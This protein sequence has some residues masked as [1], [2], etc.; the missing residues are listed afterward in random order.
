M[1]L[2]FEDS[3]FD[4]IARAE[5]PLLQAKA[6]LLRHRPLGTEVLALE[7]ADAESVFSIA[8]PTPPADSTGAG[9]ILEHMVFRGSRGFPLD[10]PFSAL[11]AGS[12]ASYLNASTR[13]DLTT[14]HG[15]SLHA[16]DLANLTEVCLDAVLNPLLEEAAFRQEAWRREPGPPPALAG[17][18]LNEMKGHWSAPGA[19]LL[20]ALR[21]GLFPDSPYRHAY[22]GDPAAIPDLTPEALRAF[23][24]RFYHPSGAKILLW[25]SA[26]LGPRLAQI[27]RHLEDFAPRPPQPEALGQ[28]PFDAP[29]RVEIGF[30]GEARMSGA[31]WALAAAEAPRLLRLLETALIGLPL[32]PLKSLGGASLIGGSG[33]SLETAQ[34]FLALG[35][36][37]GAPEAVEAALGAR[38]AALAAGD[39]PPG[40]VGAALNQMAFRLR[41]TDG[42]P[43]KPRGLQVWE[44]ILGPWRHGG[45]PL[46]ALRDEEAEGARDP[47]AA[48]AALSRL[49]RAGLLENPHR[50]A[51]VL[52]PDPG[53]AA[54]AARRE[55]LRAA[56]APS[57]PPP[58]PRAAAAGVPPPAL[59]REDLPRRAPQVETRR[60]GDILLVKAPEDGILRLDLALDVSRAPE[61]LLDLA[62]LLGRALTVLG[63]RRRDAAAFNAALL[64]RTGGF[65]AQAW[66]SGSAARLIL[67]G[68]ALKPD[69]AALLEVMEEALVSARLEDPA[70][71]GGLLEEALAEHQARLARMTHQVLDLRLKGGAQERLNGLTQIAA[72]KAARTRL[73]ADGPGLLRDLQALLD[74]ARRAPILGLGGD[75]DPAPYAAFL[76]RVALPGGGEA[77]PSPQEALQDSEGFVLA[78]PVNAVGLAADLAGFGVPRGVFALAAHAVET[79]W[80]WDEIRVAGGAYGA[81]ASLGE[82]GLLTFFSFRDPHLLRSLDR[83][84]ESGVWLAKA[85]DAALT[86]R[87]RI[88]AVGRM[89]QPKPPG[90]LTLEALQRHLR[91]TD[92]AQR[93]AGL[94]AALACAPED[95]RRAG[96][97]LAAAC[98]QGRAVVIGGRAALEAAL[99][100]RP[101]AFILREAP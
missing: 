22:G 17:V 31:A 89:L 72:L 8:F 9:H 99:A 6:R 54:E 70:A 83:Y 12:M 96:E 86:E 60:E 65:A 45:D 34:P 52:R 32:S 91:G 82:E 85:A 71:I 55:A 57:D 36:S 58:P 10:Q 35:W 81:R 94:E 24:R 48:Q 75:E 98:A 62:P 18:V 87:W 68:K 39:W 23:H 73:Q 16:G 101:G 50:L 40:L 66:A 21:R 77:A 93:Q 11:L 100:E 41:E 7:T 20:E 47:E 69:R 95:L 51:A 63:T 42:F 59:R 64:T 25:G 78:A 46:A 13:P 43:P 5:L 67:R 84:R 28:A 2:T 26:P 74:L 88:G 19:V 44:R 80:L 37:G 33:L 56:T 79:G 90:A 29:R 61:A 3:A 92:P 76:G 27:A 53:L 49:I 14:Y 1:P 30:A 38:L 4:E 97:A 15:A